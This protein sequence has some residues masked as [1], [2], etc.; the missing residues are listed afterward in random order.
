MLVSSVNPL[1]PS[2]ERSW[3]SG[4]Y[5]L[6]SMMVLN[7]SSVLLDVGWSV[8]ITVMSIINVLVSTV[9]RLVPRSVVNIVIFVDSIVVDC[10]ELSSVCCGSV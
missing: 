7:D 10:A 1:V 3:K 8:M 6:V 9:V 5:L 2:E 4:L